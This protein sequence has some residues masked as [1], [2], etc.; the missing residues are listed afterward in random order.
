[1]TFKYKITSSS[2]LNDNEEFDLN[3][4][5]KLFCEN[6]KK[7]YKYKETI[8]FKDKIFWKKNK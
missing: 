5:D 8:T 4:F 1:M 7:K 6:E 2:Q 3:N